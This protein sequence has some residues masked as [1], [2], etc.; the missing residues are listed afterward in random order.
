MIKKSA[1]IVMVLLA[2][3][4]SACEQPQSTPPVA[5]TMSEPKVQ[6]SATVDPNA[7]LDPM[8]DLA[9][10]GTQT[11]VAALGGE[12]LPPLD[13][14]GLATI[15]PDAGGEQPTIDPL[16]AAPTSDVPVLAT[17]TPQPVDKPGTYTL[18]KGEFI[19]C[20]A[21]RFDVDV[22]QTLKINGLFDSETLQPG[23]TVKIPAGGKFSGVRALKAHPATYTVKAQDTI[24]SIACLY[25]DVDPM[26]IAAVNGLAAPYTLTPGAQIQI[27]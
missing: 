21:R 27:P 6:A 24:Y 4:L 20:L 15:T 13:G 8:E 2:V 9:L 19:F 14:D 12:E 23:L 7:P 18:Q 10:F 16:L 5:P 11:A 26:N 17:V 3:L 25:G 1:L 22:N